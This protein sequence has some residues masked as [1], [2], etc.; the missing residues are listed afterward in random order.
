MKHLYHHICFISYINILLSYM[1][2]QLFLS[3][4]HYY[5]LFI[6]FSNW[7][8]AKK[9]VIRNSVKFTGKLLCQSLFFNINTGQAYNFIKKGTLAQVFSREFCKIS[10]NI[11]SYGTP[12]VAT[13]GE[14]GLK[15]CTEIKYFTK[16]VA[17]YTNIQICQQNVFLY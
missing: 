8:S 1:T 15:M 16:C 13:F 5:L 4:I 17:K 3:F 12:L 7:C 10:K 11:L 2:I 14:Y 9:D 6:D